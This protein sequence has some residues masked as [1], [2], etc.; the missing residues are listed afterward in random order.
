MQ[1]SPQV[2]VRLTSIDHKLVGVLLE[3]LDRARIYC[4]SRCAMFFPLIDIAAE[5]VGI[6]LR[7][8]GIRHDDGAVWSTQWAPDYVRGGIGRGSVVNDDGATLF[9]A[10]L[11]RRVGHYVVNRVVDTVGGGIANGK[12]VD[13][14][15]FL[16]GR[17][18]CYDGH[19]RARNIFVVGDVVDD[20]AP[21]F[22][23]SGGLMGKLLAMFRV[24]LVRVVSYQLAFILPA[25][26]R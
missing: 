20:G 17:D 13:E 10:K 7:A 24:A 14:N 6:D 2:V 18:I 25:H 12:F 3:N 9:V 8:I 5:T 23:V 19:A 16:H 1:A 15:P 26:G 4:A 21:G 11:E 22:E